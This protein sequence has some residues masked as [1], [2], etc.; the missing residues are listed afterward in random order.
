[1]SGVRIGGAPRGFAA[2]L[3]AAG[4]GAFA[5]LYAVQ[6][7]MPA[8]AREWRLGTAAAT[9]SLS[10]STLCL[11]LALPF[12]AQLADRLGRARVIAF[13]LYAAA[14]LG[15]ACAVVPGFA[16]LLA[17][18]GLLGLALA[19]VPSLA[20]TLVAETLPPALA[21]AMVGQFIAGSAFGGMSGRLIAALLLHL[22]GWRGATLVIGVMALAAALVFDRA[23]AARAPS[24]PLAI[25]A[26]SG[27]LA[28]LAEPGLA[29][30]IL[31]AGLLMGGFVTAFNLISFRLQAPPFGLGAAASGAVFLLYACGI[32]VS[33]LSGGLSARLGAGWL[34]RAGLAAMLAGGVIGIANSL[35]AVMAGMTLI[36]VGFFAAHAA[37]S[38]SVA[39]TT[40]PARAG[41]SA[42]YSMVYYL[43][44][45]LFGP[46]G[47]L[48][49]HEGGSAGAGGF[50]AAL[51]LGGLCMVALWARAD[52][53]VRFSGDPGALG[54]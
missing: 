9:L 6:P 21:P 53:D 4:F 26:R 36:T 25:A 22:L 37:A 23:V 12:A 10:I 28:P 51:A 11:A 46:L 16:A 24:G 34:M 44:S 38:A 18:R 17:A 29:P 3:F 39:A 35:A 31:L 5:L 13:S 8:L 30:L 7:L 20:L 45:A 15:M 54:A 47:G 41:A 42:L 49:W 1:M 40:G 2:G 14:G 50:I 27:I 43:G 19:G 52:R 33:A 32:V 48:A